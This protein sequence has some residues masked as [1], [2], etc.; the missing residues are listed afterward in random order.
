MGVSFHFEKTVELKKRKK[1]KLFIEDL[2]LTEKTEMKEVSIIFCSDQYILKINQ[3]FLSHDYYTDIITFDLTENSNL[4]KIGEIY[5]GVD[6]VLS[7][8]LLLKVDFNEELH[9]VIFHGMLHLCGYSDISKKDV[10]AMRNREDYY[11]SKWL[12]LSKN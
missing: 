8:T 2:F 4:S 9:R 5:I 10:T 7:N 1:L 12:S 11:L 3:E 6:T